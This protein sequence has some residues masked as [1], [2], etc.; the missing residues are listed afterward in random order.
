M[1]NFSGSWQL[2]ISEYN[3]QFRDQSESFKNFPV[4]RP[5][6]VRMRAAI[7]AI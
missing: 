5:I 1:K 6:E 2:D 7:H 3:K 4:V